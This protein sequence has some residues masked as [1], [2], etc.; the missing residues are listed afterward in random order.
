MAQVLPHPPVTPFDWF[1]DRDNKFLYAITITANKDGMR[2]YLLT[3][4]PL[5]AL[6]DGDVAFARKDIKHVVF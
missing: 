6:G 4:F 3:K 2:D 1:V 5:P